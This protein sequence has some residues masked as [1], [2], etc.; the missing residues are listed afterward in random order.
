LMT[1]PVEG[2]APDSP[3]SALSAADEYVVREW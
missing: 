1:E 3:C 2:V